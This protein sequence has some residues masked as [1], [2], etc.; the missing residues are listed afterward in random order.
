M[1]LGNRPVENNVLLFFFVG[2][3]GHRS[4]VVRLTGGTGTIFGDQIREQE[5]SLI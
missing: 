2:L 5:W 4:E 1:F 3:V